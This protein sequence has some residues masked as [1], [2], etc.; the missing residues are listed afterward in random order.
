MISF[1]FTFSKFD[2]KIRKPAFKLHDFSVNL[3]A[4]AGFQNAP[5]SNRVLDLVNKLVK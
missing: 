2:E 4:S 1:L 3:L 5:R